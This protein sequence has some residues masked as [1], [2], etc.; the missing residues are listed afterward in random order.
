MG[1]K[2]EE[3]SGFGSRQKQFLELVLQES[4]FLK[5]FY[6]T[7][8]TALSCWY[9]H[10]RE[11]YDLDFFSPDEVNPSRISKWI[12]ANKKKLGINSFRFETQLGFNFFYLEYSPSEILK[13]DFSYFP[14]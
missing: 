8:G 9:L 13:V 14:V 1:Q 2:M 3:G 5:K 12:L 11:S 6:L 10:H 7:G 4:Y